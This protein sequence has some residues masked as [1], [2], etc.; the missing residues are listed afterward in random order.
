MNQPDSN[1]AQ[2]PSSLPT[3]IN[4]RELVPG[5][6]VKLADDVIVE[7]VE[8]PEDGMWIRGKYV[9]VPGNSALEGT[10]DQIFA[11]D[12]LDRA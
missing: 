11:T 8:N 1:Q 9:S 10:M 4:L 7:V 2:N 12:V 5:E 3:R 6:K